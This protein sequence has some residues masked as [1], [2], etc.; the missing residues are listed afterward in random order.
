VKIIKNRAKIYNQSKK[1]ISI[2]EYIYKENKDNSACIIEIL[3]HFQFRE[4]MVYIILLSS[5]LYSNYW[6]PLCMTYLNLIIL[7]DYL[8]IH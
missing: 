4:H 1:E 6:N 7:T 3:S 8:W 2:L 5:V